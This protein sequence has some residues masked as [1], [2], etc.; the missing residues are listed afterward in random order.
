MASPTMIGRDRELRQLLAVLAEALEGVP[1]AVVVAGEAGIGKTRL[2]AEFQVQASASARILVGQCVDLGA[3]GVP[4]APIISVLRSL[5]Q[6]AGAD[7]VLAAA[8]PGR[9]ALTLLLPELT[10]RPADRAAAGLERLHEMVAVILETFARD[11]PIVVVIED[12]HWVDS[13]SLTALQFL[14]NAVTA[15]RIMLLLS[16]RS[17]D[18]SRG[19]PLR[20]FLSNAER[21]RVL[22]RIQLGRLGF[23][24]VEAQ[25]RGILGTQPDPDTLA[26]VF[27]RSEGVPFFVEELVDRDCVGLP[28][29]L[30]DLLLARYDRLSDAAQ[31]LLRM[32]SAG[33]MRV[34]HRLLAAVFEQPTPGRT[35]SDLDAA[36]REAVSAN[37][38]ETEED[39]YTF[40]HA[41]VRE[42]IEA[43]LLPGERAR[44]HTGFAEALEAAGDCSSSEVAQ[45]WFAA[46]NPAR[47]FPS[48]LTAMT[49][50][51]HA[52]AYATA[53]QLGERALSLWDQ[54]PDAEE[55]AGRTR[56]D[57]LAKTASALRNAGDGERALAM[58]D[59]A[60]DEYDSDGVTL[61]RL[62]RDK[63]NYLG[64]IA[65]AGSVLLLERALELVP[66]GVNERLRV[67]LLNALAGR[68]MLEGDLGRALDAA[69]QAAELAATLD[70]PAQAS[71]AANVAG[72]CKAHLGRVEEGLAQLD[73]ARPLAQGDPGAMLRYRVNASD[74][75][76][77]LGQYEWA[78]A[79]A[80]KG[81]QRAREL[82]VERVSGVILAANAIEPLIALGRWDRAEQLTDRMLALAPSA[83]FKLFL[84][85]SKLSM[86]LRRGHVEAAY[87]Q[88]RE[89]RQALIRGGQAETQNRF[90][91]ARVLAELL[92]ECG[93][94][95]GALE[96]VAFLLD[97]RHRPLPAYGVPLLAVAARVLA[98]CRDSGA[99]LPPEF[100]TGESRLRALMESMRSWPTWPVWNS[101]FEAELATEHQV[102]A[103]A[104]AA[105]RAPDGTA[106]LVPY[107]LF[108][109]GQAQ[110]TAGN[111]TAGQD[112]L[113]AAVA[114]AR[115]LGA[116]LIVD[117]AT[118]FAERAGLVLADQQPVRASAGL[119]LTAR[120]RQV[121]EL[122]EEG[123][124]NRQIGER[125][126][127]SSK[128]AS[129]H[130]S[131]ILR[132][133]GAATRTEAAVLASRALV[134]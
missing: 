35:P 45:H 94:L 58:V 67:S 25:A 12:L 34:S 19:H 68:L 90:G 6:Q 22:T 56:V 125:L 74:L 110:T 101:Q 64:Q 78:L 9:E 99:A 72:L 15:G 38:L 14:L 66:P 103:W 10:V 30:R 112:S 129:V 54:V 33:G 3:A 124:S 122:V 108:R 21:A 120:E 4:Y 113:R 71:V 63:A 109:L 11:Q 98:A 1:R 65:Q 86:L 119:Q 2:L 37:V 28:D 17:D 31:Y 81:M 20:A 26:G 23:A 121:L 104:L 106:W 41:L 91:N 60:I 51:K 134:P 85:Q 77:H 36:A 89:W 100:A 131:A 115:E 111:R 84:Q 29:T 133:L 130:V 118:A 128:T 102:E 39:S 62:L 47:A 69:T 24:E 93:D 53:A 50:A 27:E 88:Y 82:G 107:S 16:Y 48:A 52:Y 114:A 13:A 79:I 70:V 87:A 95:D 18:V 7:A 127:I 97:T 55:V 5:V 73:S 76:F 105:E 61:A 132:K 117:R 43:D 49:D 92:L 46:G 116:G 96:Q 57:L 75:R 126:F 40:R 42:A 59:V 8:G 80:E 44:F 123:L 32:L 83:G